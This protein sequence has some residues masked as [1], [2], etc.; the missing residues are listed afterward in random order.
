MT[1]KQYLVVVAAQLVIIVTIVSILS[2]GFLETSD[3]RIEKI[4][5]EVTDSSSWKG[6]L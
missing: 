4:K 2:S 5:I 6:M 3:E 1:K